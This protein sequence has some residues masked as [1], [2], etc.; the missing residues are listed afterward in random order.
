MA[1]GLTGPGDFV[2]DSCTLV[3]TSGKK[4]DLTASIIGITLYEGINSAAVTGELVITDAANLSSTGPIVGHEY[5]FLKI[6]IIH[7]YKSIVID[8]NILN[9]FAGWFRF[10]LSLNSIL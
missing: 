9:I 7:R 8:K 10:L 4:I 3:T 5:L 1:E 2:L 6:I